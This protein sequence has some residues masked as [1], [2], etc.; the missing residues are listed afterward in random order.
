MTQVER[1]RYISVFHTVTTQAPYKSCYD[2]LI[3]IHRVQFSTAIHLESFFLPWHRWYILS[4]EN[5]LRQIDCKVTVPY[6]DW[7][8]ESQ[9]WQNSIV[10]APQCGFGGNGS[11]VTTGPF[12]DGN[13]WELT[14]S[15]IPGGPLRRNFQGTI[16]DCAA[17]AMIQRLGVSEFSSWHDLVYNNLHNSMHCN[18]HGTMCSQ[19]SANAPEFFLHHG[20][21]D[22]VWAQWQNKG[23]SFKNLPHYSQN[24]DAMPGAYGN[25]PRDVYDLDSQPGCVHVCVQPP[26]RPC[27]VNTSYTPLCPREMN[28][29][30]YSPNKLADLIYRPYPRVPLD[31]YRLFGVP[32]ERRRLPERC[33]DLFNSQD[34]L[35]EVLESN[36]YH[37][38]SGTTTYRPA[39]G[40][41]QLDNYFYRPVRPVYPTTPNGTSYSPPPPPQECQPY[42]DPYL[43]GGN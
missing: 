36:G 10:W 14:P 13:N 24:S 34:D 5:L 26:S 6:W 43:Y 40:E 25:A 20:F 2:Q 4:L 9:N 1:C 8:G 33:A 39:L 38:G 17:V 19:D 15:A 3:Q 22:Q 11:P 18:I 7:S 35:Y 21:I 31:S 12:S 27:R 29:Y 28:C 32:P 42:I 41:V 30:E 23:P 37:V 16:P